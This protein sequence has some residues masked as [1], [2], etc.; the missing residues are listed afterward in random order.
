M[1]PLGGA[2]FNLGMSRSFKPPK[3]GPAYLVA[4]NTIRGTFDIEAQHQPPYDTRPGAKLG[5]SSFEKHF[6]GPLEA[7]SHVEML[8]ALTDVEGSAGYVALERVVGLLEGRSGSFVLQHSGLLDRGASSLS[9][10]VV[11]DSAT[12]ELAGLR[13]TMTI[14]IIDGEHHYGFE[15]SF[16]R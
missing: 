4:M 2:C 16:R 9:V 11:P 6:H 7:D 8:G 14:E 13:G 5:R 10:T 15:Y 3:R 1:S 12:E